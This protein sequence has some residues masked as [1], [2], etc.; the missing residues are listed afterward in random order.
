MKRKIHILIIC[1]VAMLGMGCPA[2]A[3]DSPFNVDSWSTAD[4]LPQSSIIAITQT[5]DGYLWLGTL[6]G[7]VRFDGNSFTR[8]NVNNTPGLPSDRIVFLFE[9][10]QGDLWV[11]TDSAGLA[12]IH[13]GTMRDFPAS[14]AAGPVNGAFQD[15]DGNIWFS[16]RNGKFLCWKNGHLELRETDV[17]VELVMRLFYQTAHLQVEGKGDV[18]WSLQGS[19][20]RKLRAEIGRASCRERV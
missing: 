2:L 3:G 11:G 7:L 4:G 10:G 6:N 8:F 12:V 15:A 19:Q 17:P 13:N 18:V 16:T 5:H 9:D 14:S 1:I 20:I